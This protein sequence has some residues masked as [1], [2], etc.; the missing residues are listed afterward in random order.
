MSENFDAFDDGL[1]PDPIDRGSG[2]VMGGGGGGGSYIDPSYEDALRIMGRA[3]EMPS[4]FEQRALMMDNAE[5]AELARRLTTLRRTAGADVGPFAA[6]PTL[7][8]P[9]EEPPAGQAVQELIGALQES[10]PDQQ[11]LAGLCRQIEQAGGEIEAALEQ[12]CQDPC[13]QSKL[14]GDDCFSLNAFQIGP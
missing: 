11:R 1:G 7:G 6:L 8:E 4:P 5:A 9:A 13:V 2:K 12:V 10:P 3:Y 14:K